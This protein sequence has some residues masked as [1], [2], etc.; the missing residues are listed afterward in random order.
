VLTD[1]YSR[2]PARHEALELVAAATLEGAGAE[3]HRGTLD[4]LDGLRSAAAA[5]DGVIHT[6]YIHDFSQMEDA[7]ATDLRAIEA[8]GAALEGSG[9]PLVITTGTALVKPGE[10]ATE[11]DSIAPGPGAHPAG[12]PPSRSRTHWL[13]EKCARP[14]CAPE[15]RCSANATTASCRT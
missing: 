4:D 12:R 7:A 6:A 14:S 5:A 13:S 2:R 1:R 15:R 3:V 11:G 8:L 9:R 10:V